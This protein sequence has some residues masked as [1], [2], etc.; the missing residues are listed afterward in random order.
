MLERVGAV[1]MPIDF[2]V[3]YKD[4]TQVIH[5]I[6]MQMMFGEKP[7]MTDVS[8]WVIEKDWAWARPTYSIL[9]DAPIEEILQL[10]ID[11]TGLMADIDLSN[12]VFENTQ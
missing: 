12:N 6:P 1:G 8:N 7:P 2:G 11:P 5:Y 3:F 10:R 9:L 4:G